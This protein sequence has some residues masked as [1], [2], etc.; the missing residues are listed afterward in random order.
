[1]VS[2]GRCWEAKGPQQGSP[3][4]LGLGSLPEQRGGLS[5]M[6]RPRKKGLLSPPVLSGVG[7][8]RE[9]ATIQGLPSAKAVGTLSLLS[10]GPSWDQPVLTQA[11]GVRAAGETTNRGT[12]R[13]RQTPGGSGPQRPLE[14]DP[15][16]SLS[17]LQGRRGAALMY[18][19]ARCCFGGRSH[20]PT[21]GGR[22]G[23]WLLDL[24]LPGKPHRAG[25]QPPLWLHVRATS[26][27]T[28]LS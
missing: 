5:H 9:T 27:P 7:M 18:H 24:R 3:H 8:A 25:H 20:S 16:P 14:G 21:D 17:V 22:P 15:E 11:C 10:W 19:A 23:A 12:G 6:A 4:Q 13:D 28:L 2:A 1:M 26:L